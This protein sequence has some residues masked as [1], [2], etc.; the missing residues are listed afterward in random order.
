ML[1]PDELPEAALTRKGLA[2]RPGTQRSPGGPGNPDGRIGKARGPGPGPRRARGSRAQSVG[3][4]R[5]ARVAARA[6]SEPRTPCLPLRSP[7]RFRTPPW[8]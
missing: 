6:E 5:G 2:C 3:W 8:R 7:P 4:P 1:V